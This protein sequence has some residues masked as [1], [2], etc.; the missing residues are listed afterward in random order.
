MAAVGLRTYCQCHAQRRDRGCV[1]KTVALPLATAR[2]LAPIP[3]ASLSSALSLSAIRAVS[4]I[5]AM[6]CRPAV[7]AAPLLPIAARLFARWLVA[8]AAAALLAACA[9]VPPPPAA[10]T[11]QAAAIRACQEEVELQSCA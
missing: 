9:L 3:V 4:A 11:L 2:G 8:A 1:C 10:S 5:P 6:L 7:R